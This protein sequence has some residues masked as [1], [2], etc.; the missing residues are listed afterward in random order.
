MAFLRRL[1]P[2]H[3]LSGRRGLAGVVEQGHDAAIEGRHNQLTAIRGLAGAFG[4]ELHLED[5]DVVPL[6]ADVRD[7]AEG[8]GGTVGGRATD[9]IRHLDHFLWWKRGE[10]DPSIVTGVSQKAEA[11]WTKT[12]RPLK[13]R[14]V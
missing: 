11:M 5:R 12:V 10:C 3:G 13:E 6:S 14:N 2:L 9:L 7:Q 4:V 8:R 1:K